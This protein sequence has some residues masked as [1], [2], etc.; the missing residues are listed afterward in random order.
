ML[1]LVP[2][3]PRVAFLC[4]CALLLVA[5]APLAYGWARV[6]PEDAPPLAPVER[7][8]SQPGRF[9]HSDEPGARPSAFAVLLLG[10]VTASYVVELPG[11]PRDAFLRYLEGLVPETQ[12]HWVAIAIGGLFVFVPGA[13]ACYAVLRPGPLR[14]PLIAGGVFVL[15]LWLAHPYLF[16]S[17]VGSP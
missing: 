15:L 10:F 7:D 17:L 9:V 11:I 6:L 4:L 3:D 14:V 8:T 5:A 2:L 13:A 16:A 1:A 12:V